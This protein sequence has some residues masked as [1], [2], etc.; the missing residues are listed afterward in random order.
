M[1]AVA[2][3]ILLAR[4]RPAAPPAARVVR[5]TTVGMLAAAVGFILRFGSNLPVWDEWML[6]PSALARPFPVGW[7]WEFHC[8][9]RYP[10]GKA[11]W[12]VLLAVSGADFRSGMVA[13]AG[14]SAAA[15]GLLAGAA[16]RLRGRAAVGDVLFAAVALH[17]GHWFNFVMGYQVAFALV[18]LAGAGLLRVA[19]AAEPGREG[20]TG[21]AAGGLLLVMLAGGGFGLAFLP[22]LAAW[23]AYLAWRTG[24]LPTA[25]LLLVAPA[26]G[27]AYAGWT[28]AH[29]PP[30]PAGARP[31]L[32]VPVRAA[33]YLL[34]AVGTPVCESPAVRLAVGA[35]VVAGHAAAAGLLL[36]ALV[37]LPAERP[38]AAGMLAVLVGH[39]G[40]ALGIA[41]SRTE[42]LADRYSTTSVIGPAVVVLAL[43]RYGPAVGRV[44]PV[45]GVLAAAALVLANAAGG[46]DR[47]SHYWMSNKMFRA[48]LRAGVPPTFLSGKYAWA[49]CLWVHDPER[50][51]LLRDLGCR[52]FAGVP[53]DPPMRAVPAG[54]PVPFAAPPTRAVAALGEADAPTAV[55]LPPPA[56]PVL[57]LRVA[58][59]TP[60]RADGVVRVRWTGATGRRA[61]V[62]HTGPTTGWV[63]AFY[64]PGERPTDA[65]LDV[66]CPGTGAEITAVEWLVPDP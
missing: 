43:V 31:L 23:V 3:R 24:R 44:G 16:A 18:L 9:H 14:L 1:F 54:V 57:G 29:M 52:E 40:V 11:L 45:L 8:E 2:A 33:G 5:W 26:A 59:R 7:L 6:F 10:L 55:R 56:G 66:A 20:R 36:R 49:C 19:A 42:G 28:V 38:R 27:V 47:G 41:I 64:M 25:A 30:S 50:V 46:H 35:V 21:L 60:D 58:V 4:P 61:E 53:D 22:P 34:T 51:R 13:V 48:E 32:G 39:G 37:R 12:A 62:A 15:A 65:V 17:W 63:L